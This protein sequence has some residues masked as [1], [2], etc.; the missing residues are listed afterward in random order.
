MKTNSKNSKKSTNTKKKNSK[1]KNKRTKIKKP[2]RIVIV[3]AVVSIIVLLTALII[4]NVKK[5]ADNAKIQSNI[6][7]ISDINVLLKNGDNS[8]WDIVSVSCDSGM[9]WSENGQEHSANPGELIT[10]SSNRPTGT[11]IELAPTEVDGRFTVKNGSTK[12]GDNYPGL[13]H[14]HYTSNGLQVTN[15]VPLEEYISGVICSEMPSSYGLEALKAQAVCARSYVLSKGGALGYEE[16]GAHVDDSTSYQVYGKTWASG[17]ALDAVIETAGEVVI[18][19]DGTVADTMFYSTSNGYS[20]TQ[21]ADKF[22]YLAR[23]Y[24]SLSNTDPLK[25]AKVLTDDKVIDTSKS[26]ED[27]F[28]IYIKN[29]DENALEN[30]MQYFRW[31]CDL[32]MNAGLDKV[33]EAIV[34]NY[35]SV[36][37]TKNDEGNVK[38]ELDD[39]MRKHVLDASHN[40]LNKNGFGAFKGMEVKK[41]STGGVITSLS[42]EFENGC[43]IINDELLIRK[44]LGKATDSV[45]LTGNSKKDTTSLPSAAFSFTPVE[46]GY[47]VYGGGF[48]HG[49]GMSQSGAKALAAEGKNYKEILKF[50]YKDCDVLREE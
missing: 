21:K 12:K 14:L 34:S 40:T 32:D 49:C 3:I 39:N 27:A 41:R 11:V 16:A 31:E 47:H 42:V 22:P 29:Q 18:A 25:E 44:I 13:I 1:R 20:Q 10:F 43:V 8:T 19:P 36:N 24:I 9:R 45:T 28:A 7:S 33:K 23:K 6:N 4:Y 17:D 37:T 48:G 46:K 26:I 5:S 2:L 30:G 50:F 15:L 35:T 38:L